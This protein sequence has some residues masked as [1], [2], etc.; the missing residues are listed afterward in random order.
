MSYPIDKYKFYRDGKNVIAVS[1]YAGRT[2]RGVAKLDPRDD[3]DEDFGKKL[4]SARCNA[5][6]TNKRMKNALKKYEKAVK[7]VTEAKRM[8]SAM[9]RYYLDAIYEANE[10]QHDLDELMK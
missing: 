10:A 3:F 5:K 8:E 7:T 2:V 4:A 1:S 9:K 6:I